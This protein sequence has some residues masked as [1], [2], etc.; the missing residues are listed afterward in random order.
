MHEPGDEY[1]RTEPPTTHGGDAQHRAE[2]IR[3]RTR[4]ESEQG[5]L[6]I[7]T[8]DQERDGEQDAVVAEGVRHRERRDEHPPVATSEDRE[9]TRPSSMSIEFVIHE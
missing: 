3:G 7:A 9:R 1:Q 2:E 5:R 4:D 8:D 6:N